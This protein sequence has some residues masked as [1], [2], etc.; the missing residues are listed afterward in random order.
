MNTTNRRLLV[1]DD[2]RL[3]LAMLVSGLKAA[4]FEVIQAENGDEAI[5]AARAAQPDLALLDIRMEGKSGLDVA[6]YLRA[7]TK[8]PFLFLS[9]FNDSE[10]VQEAAAFGALGYLVKPLDIRQVIPA[11]HAALA[12]AAE[13]K[14]LK[15]DE[16][17]PIALPT[18]E[19]AIWLAAGILAERHRLSVAEAMDRL[20]RSAIAQDINEETLARQVL[21]A[22]AKLNSVLR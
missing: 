20:K 18:A 13:I 12:R 11:I 16:S 7:N 19:Q 15:A 6:R 10:M 3:V 22:A 14:A 1:V 4:G 17:A 8:V 21:E 2:D 5:L 9:A